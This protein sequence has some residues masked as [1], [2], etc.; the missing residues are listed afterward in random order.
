MSG[1]L[2]QPIKKFTSSGSKNA[3]YLPIFFL[4]GSDIIN[5]FYCDIPKK[6]KISPWSLSIFLIPFDNYTWI[7]LTVAL[8]IL[9]KLINLETYPAR[10]SST[11]MSIITALLAE[12]LQARLS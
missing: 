7:S 12:L 6:L 8:I 2:D 1:C 3:K 5:I 4:L 10:I 9:T 11:M